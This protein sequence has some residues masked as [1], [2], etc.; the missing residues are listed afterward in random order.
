MQRP[1]ILVIMGIGLIGIIFVALED[2]PKAMPRRVEVRSVSVAPPVKVVLE[3]SRED[4][5]VDVYSYAYAAKGKLSKGDF[6]Q[7][8][9]FELLQADWNA[10]LTPLV[11]G[12]RDPNM[13]PEE[14]ARSA[15]RYLNEAEMIKVKM[16]IAAAQVEDSSARSI[17]R[18][19]ADINSQIFVAWED[20]RQAMANGLVDRLGTL[21]DAIDEAKKLAGI[22][23]DDAIDRVLLP[24]PRSLFDD[25][26]GATATGGDPVARMASALGTTT[27]IRGLLLARIAGLPGLESLAAEADALALV[28][29]GRPQLLMPVR[30][31]VR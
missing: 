23:A 17:V 14:W 24:E 2:E 3:A 8:V 25:L 10:A 11:R 27:A 15:R 7:I 18:Q 6:R 28:L 4:Q 9:K 12:L 16:G 19:I 13:V 1:L 26:L 21:D 31:R 22:D 29:S 30:I 20:V 5:M